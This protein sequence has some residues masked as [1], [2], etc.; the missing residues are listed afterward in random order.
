VTLTAIIPG[1]ALVSSLNPSNVG[2]N[3]TFTATVTGV[4]P[5]GSV[6]FVADSVTTLCNAVPLS[7]GGSTP[8]AQCGTTALTA[9]THS[10]V[11]SYSGDGSNAPS[12][13]T[14]LSQVVNT[15]PPPPPAL[16]NAGFETPALGSGFQYNPSG[17]G[18][19][20]TFSASSGIQHNGSAWGAAAA[21][22]GVQTAFVQSTGTISQALSLN[23]GNYTLAFKAAQRNCCLTPNTQPVQVSLDGAPLGS[24]VTPASTSF[25][26]FSIPLTVA[27]S[28]THTIAFAGTA[29]NSNST[30][31]DAVSLAAL[32]PGTTL[33]S[34]LNPAKRSQS[35]TFTATVTGT[36]PTGTVGFTSNGSAIT[37]CTAVAFSA[38]SGNI[39][40]AKCV[41]TFA[42][43]GGYNIVAN[44]SGDG[45]NAPT[46]ST[47]LVET[48][49]AKK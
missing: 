30:F 47:T 24:P 22:E 44:Y 20:W 36:N 45:G 25:G 7:G 28:G 37:G 29:A 49:K 16:V 15:A 4:T 42:V 1:T 21:P 34:S 27:S 40:T 2:D 17:A 26:S 41:T 48:I 23:A 14:A 11:A 39:R 10:I 12:N 18:I 31:I 5:T 38:G 33:A 19:G 6:T 43:A 13:S 32:V 35:V 9:G 46:S 3:V 8:T